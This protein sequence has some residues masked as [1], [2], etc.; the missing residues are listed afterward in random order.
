[1]EYDEEQVSDVIGHILVF[2][3]PQHAKHTKATGCYIVD[4]GARSDPTCCQ[5]H[6]QDMDALAVRP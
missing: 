3:Q 2:R 1:M 6:L 5:E 4:N